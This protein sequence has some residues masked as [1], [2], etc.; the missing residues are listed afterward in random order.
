MD[1]LERR[2]GAW[3]SCG[4][5]TRISLPQLE[6]AALEKVALPSWVPSWFNRH[7]AGPCGNKLSSWAKAKQQVLHVE[8]F[9]N[10]VCIGKMST[11]PFTDV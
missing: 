5:R 9:G 4:H 7:P 8:R 10:C 1:A 11:R 3:C 6:R 2:R